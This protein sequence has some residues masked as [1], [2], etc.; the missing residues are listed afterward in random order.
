MDYNVKDSFD[1]VQKFTTTGLQEDFT[2]V[3][4]DDVPNELG[5]KVITEYWIQILPHVKVKQDMVLEIV[6]FCFESGYFSY[7]TD[8]YSQLDGCSMGNPVS[9]SIANIIATTYTLLVQL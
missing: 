4:L 3:Y 9:P 1:F 8:L 2:M 5:V 6:N 7:Q